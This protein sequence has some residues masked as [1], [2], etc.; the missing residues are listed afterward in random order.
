MSLKDK[1]TP[2]NRAYWAFVEQTARDCAATLPNWAQKQQGHDPDMRRTRW[3]CGCEG[4]GYASSH[5]S[6]PYHTNSVV[7]SVT[8][9]VST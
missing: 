5:T 8:Y 9:D 3:T 4:V 2:E 6:C 7:E 1:S